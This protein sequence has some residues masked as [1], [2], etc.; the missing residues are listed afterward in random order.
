V[1]AFVAIAVIWFGGGRIVRNKLVSLAIALGLSLAGSATILIRQSTA[2]LGIVLP[3]VVLLGWAAH[4]IKFAD[5]DGR[6]K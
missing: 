3:V 2:N 6:G 4:D 5:D 1:I